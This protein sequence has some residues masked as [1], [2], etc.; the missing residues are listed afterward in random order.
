[1]LLL[2]FLPLIARALPY[3]L[4]GLQYLQRN[5]L[6]PAATSSSVSTGYTPL[7]LGGQCQGARYNI[8]FDIV[9][10]GSFVPNRVSNTSV[11]GVISNIFINGGGVYAVSNGTTVLLYN[12]V[13][14]DSI[15]NIRLTILDGL[16]DNC[17][18][19]PDSNPSP[20]SDTGVATS[21]APNPNDFNLLLAGIAATTAAALLAAKNAAAAA[22]LAAKNAAA[23]GN[24][25]SAVGKLAE[26][27]AEILKVLD[28]LDKKEEEE[29]EEEDVLS[30][31]FGKLTKDGFLRI[32]PN[33]TTVKYELVYLDIQVLSIPSSFGKYF[34]K[35]SP[36]YYRYKALGYISFVSPTFGILSKIDVEFNRVSF[37]PPID[38]FGFF[39]HFGLDGSVSANATGI[40]KRKILPPVPL[41]PA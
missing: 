16:T 21:P 27:L 38:S 33:E 31:D 19:I 10:N 26:A 18:N 14:V 28:E 34:G 9:T 8:M 24:T 23:A 11:D 40:Y 32:Y 37:S 13:S 6:P 5:F 20:T 22:L 3:V 12:L 30:Y 39:Y 36:N 15:S 41:P 35:K 7:Y 17:G 29:E 25:A 4:L 2:A 1:M